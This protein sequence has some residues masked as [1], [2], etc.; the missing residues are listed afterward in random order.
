MNFKADGPVLDLSAFVFELKLRTCFIFLQILDGIPEQ[1]AKKE[2]KYKISYNAVKIV[3]NY[4]D[5]AYN[6]STN[7]PTFHT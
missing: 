6:I 4:K 5:T 1:L 7:F 2:K 3:D